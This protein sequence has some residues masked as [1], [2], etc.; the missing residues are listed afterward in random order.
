VDK[1]S[2]EH[3]LVKSK[4]TKVTKTGYVVPG[5]VESLTSFFALPKGEGDIRM[6]YDGYQIWFERFNLDASF[7]FANRGKT[8]LRDVEPGCYITL[9]FMSICM[10]SVVLT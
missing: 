7:S 9:F 8:L 3:K 4:L 6:F 2:V 10:L 1:D 5:H